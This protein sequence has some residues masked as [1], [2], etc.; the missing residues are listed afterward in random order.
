MFEY[1]FI[2]P[3]N[4]RSTN[5]ITK[6]ICVQVFFLW[7]NIW[8]S[9]TGILIW[10]QEYL[11]NNFEN[12]FLLESFNAAHKNIRLYT[13]SSLTKGMKNLLLSYWLV[14]GLFI[15]LK[16]EK[17][18]INIYLYYCSCTWSLCNKCITLSSSFFD[19]SN[20]NTEKLIEFTIAQAKTFINISENLSF[21]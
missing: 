2:K 14:Y 9:Y 4:V 1:R 17:R 12:Y 15:Q 13:E 21:Y 3:N 11:C 7:P 18:R 6:Q 16:L 19:W 8:S 10:K 20:I 5:L